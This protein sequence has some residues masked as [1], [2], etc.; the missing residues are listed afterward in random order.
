MPLPTIL[1][2]LAATSIGATVISI[3]IAFR[4]ERE[5]RSAIFPIVREEE[6]IRARRARIYIFAWSAITALFLGGWLASLRLIDDSALVASD[7]AVSPVD[8]P[9]PVTEDEAGLTESATTEVEAEAAQPVAVVT[10]P[11]DTP[12]V[13]T[14]STATVPAESAELPTVTEAA[15]APTATPLV[16]PPPVTSNPT[17]TPAPPTAT[18]TNT[19]LPP[20]ATDTPEPTVTPTPTDTSTPAAFVV[21]QVPTTGPRTPA[22]P[23]ARMGPLQFATEI[24][25]DAEALDASDLFPIGVSTIYAVFPYSGMEDGLDFRVIWYQNGTELWRD[26]SEWEWGDEARFF[27]FFNSPTEGLYKVELRVNDSILA[28]GLFEVR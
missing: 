27:S 1:L 24:T 11:L 19:P 7:E 14:L 22:P 5:A 12:T 10:Q 26:E 9:A 25:D 4:S 21:I 2:I 13:Q 3:L 6:T 18:V 20:T 16:A 15:S 23:G 17:A 28:T 8:E